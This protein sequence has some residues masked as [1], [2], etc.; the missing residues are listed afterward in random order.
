MRVRV[1][2]REREFVCVCMYMRKYHKLF[3]DL[4]VLQSEDANIEDIRE[5]LRSTCVGQSMSSSWAVRRLAALQRVGRKLHCV[6]FK[7]LGDLL[8]ARISYSFH[9]V[10][11]F[12]ITDRGRGNHGVDESLA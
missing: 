3:V 5:P 10:F 11:D 1:C 2:V 7:R 9:V 4:A 8:Q 6:P 12:T